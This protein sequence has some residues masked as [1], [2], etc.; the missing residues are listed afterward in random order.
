[1][2]FVGDLLVQEET[3]K[4]GMYFDVICS[5]QAGKVRATL[6]KS[7]GQV[8]REPR[9]LVFFTDGCLRHEYAQPRWC[10]ESD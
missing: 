3:S 1:M 6:V 7:S 8:S 9:G 2:V 5:K 4:G 10:C